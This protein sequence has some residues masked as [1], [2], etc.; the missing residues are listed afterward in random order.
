LL[1]GLYRQSGTALKFQDCPFI[2]NSTSY[3][4]V[5]SVLEGLENALD[6]SGWCDTSGLT[7]LLY[8]FSDVNR[9]KPKSTEKKTTCYY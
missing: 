8:Q 5:Y 1:Y 3:K 9:G 7:P 2:K 4:S 6:C